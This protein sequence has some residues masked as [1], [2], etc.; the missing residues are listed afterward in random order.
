ML[1]FLFSIARL[2]SLD[3]IVMAYFWTFG[4]GK[5]LCF[6]KHIPT[7]N[8]PSFAL[9]VHLLLAVMF[10]VV[11]GLFWAFD[12]NRHPRLNTVKAFLCAVVLIS[13]IVF[14][15]GAARLTVRDPNAQSSIG[16]GFMFLN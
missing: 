2:F 14:H 8:I 12:S 1:S 4:L 6:V 11:E 16:L 9:N 13:V 7:L 10:A 3:E 15:Y 5:A